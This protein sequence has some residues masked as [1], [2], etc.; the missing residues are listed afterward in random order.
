MPRKPQTFR[1]AHLPPATTRSTTD[2]HYKRQRTDRDEQAF[3]SS[4]AWRKVRSL[5]LARD[6]RCVFCLEAKRLSLSEVADH[7]LPL[8]LR[9]DL[10]LE[11]TNLRGLC[12]SCHNRHTRR[13]TAAQK[14]AGGEGG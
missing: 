5:V 9:P 12:K 3:Y 8:K 1:P 2:R 14:P 11:L 13:E 4:R 10:A 6:P 7:I